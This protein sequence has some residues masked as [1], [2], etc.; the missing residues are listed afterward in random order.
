MKPLIVKDPYF[1]FALMINQFYE[2]KN[3]EFFPNTLI[4]PSAKIGKNCQIAA[5]VYIGKN[6]EI[7]DNCIIYPQATILDNVII[8]NDCII[9]ANCVIS[10]AV[11]GANCSFLMALKLVKMALVL[12]IIREKILKSIKLAL[13]RLAILLKSVLILVLIAGL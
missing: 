11:I 1:A 6:V 7:G 10:F 3:C 8:G 2:I 4:H 13:S 9:G 5:N 12:F